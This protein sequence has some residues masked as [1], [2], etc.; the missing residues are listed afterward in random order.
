MKQ[1]NHRYNKKFRFQLLANWIIENYTP[2]RVADI[3]GGKGLLSYLLNQ[4]GFQSTVIDP[5]DQELPHKYKDINTSKRILIPRD[6][7]VPR[8]TAPFDSEMAVEYDLLISLHAHGCNMMIID[9]ATTYQKDFILLPCC[10]IDEPIEVQHNVNWFESLDIYAKY[11][12]HD[13]ERVRLHFKGQS[14]VIYKTS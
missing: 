1:P 9:A 4:A 5:F 6:A 14:E 3:G 12:G 10:V 8:I 2:C 13:T 7:T 11:H